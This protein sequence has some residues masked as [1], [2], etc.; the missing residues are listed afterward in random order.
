MSP[1][2]PVP[3][4]CPQRLRVLVLNHHPEVLHAITRLLS[5]FDELVVIGQARNGPSALALAAQVFADVALVDLDLEPNRGAAIAAQI[6]GLLK[7]V[8]IV[9][10][11]QVDCDARLD[12]AAFES[13][14][15]IVEVENLNAELPVLIKQWRELAG[16]GAP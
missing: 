2:S 13:V 8:R 4:R 6:G 10:T 7:R 1:E 15:R 16:R 11:T 5:G 3:A 12:L 9:L 14:D